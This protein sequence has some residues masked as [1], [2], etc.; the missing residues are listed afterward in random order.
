MVITEQEQF[1]GIHSGWS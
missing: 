1:T